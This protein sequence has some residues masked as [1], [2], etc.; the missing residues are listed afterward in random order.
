V[1]QSDII[2]TVKTTRSL[3]IKRMEL[4][5]KTW[6]KGFESQVSLSTRA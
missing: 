6:R 3:H 5:L 4:I 1:N 2:L